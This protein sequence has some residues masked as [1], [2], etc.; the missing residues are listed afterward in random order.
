MQMPAAPTSLFLPALQLW[1][2]ACGFFIGA[3]LLHP[4][5]IFIAGILGFI[6]IIAFIAWL[7]S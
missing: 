2:A 6:S 3:M 1:I 4:F 7:L 5:L